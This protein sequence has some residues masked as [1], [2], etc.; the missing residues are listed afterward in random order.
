[1]DISEALR[2]LFGSD[3]DPKNIDPLLKSLHKRLGIDSNG[4]YQ[5]Y[6][7]LHYLKVSNVTFKK[8]I[9]PE[10]GNKLK[11]HYQVA[12][13]IILK[14]ESSLNLEERLYEELL[15]ILDNPKPL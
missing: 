5:K 8:L 4:Y 10:F 12:A 2:K 11:I 7:L 15:Y 6:Q 9:E 3:P 13:S 1:M 14:I